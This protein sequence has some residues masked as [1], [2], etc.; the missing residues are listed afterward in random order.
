MKCQ[1]AAIVPQTRERFAV[2]SGGAREYLQ[3]GDTPSPFRGLWWWFAWGML[4]MVRTDTKIG[5]Q[6]L[7][8]AGMLASAVWFNGYEYRVDVFQGLG[9]VRL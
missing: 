2:P 5:K 8:A 1:S 3:S 4:W 6:Q 9:V 7:L